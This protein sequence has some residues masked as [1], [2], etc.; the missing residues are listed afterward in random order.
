NGPHRSPTC[1]AHGRRPGGGAEGGRSQEPNG[2]GSA[3]REWTTGK[4]GR[5]HPVKVKRGCGAAAAVAI[6]RTT[7]FLGLVRSVFRRPP[8][9]GRDQSSE[10]GIY[11]RTGTDVMRADEPREAALRRCLL[12][13]L[14]GFS[15]L[16]VACRTS[17]SCPAPVAV[18]T[19]GHLC[20][21]PWC[22]MR[23]ARMVDS[24]ELEAIAARSAD[25]IWAVGS[26]SSGTGR[27]AC[28]EGPPD[29][30]PAR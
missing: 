21:G 15:W 28:P 14:L 12:A 3:T 2:S 30:G 7:P 10:G 27:A 11:E 22:T 20:V 26:T 5:T 13:A 19:P 17:F 4:G 6:S 16:S 24:N 9:R 25:D 23:T 18:P 1:H 8:N 29:L